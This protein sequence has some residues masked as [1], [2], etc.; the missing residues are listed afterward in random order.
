MSLVLGDEPRAERAEGLAALALGPLPGALDLKNALRDVVGEAIAGDHVERIVFGQIARALAD[1]DAELDF[2]VE[3]GGIFRHH[4]VVV[5]AADA[6]RRLVEDD[7]LLRDLHAGLGGVVGIIEP[8]GD[9]IADAADA[10]ADARLALHQRQ[11]FRLE[12]AQLVKPAGDNAVTR[13]IGDD[14]RQVAD[15]AFPSI[16]PG[17]SRPGA[18]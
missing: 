4:G 17:F 12:L 11:L 7:R 1:D 6:R 10:G 8:D 16:M 3:L 2:P 13:D 18:P 14:L 15:A 5:R 9:E